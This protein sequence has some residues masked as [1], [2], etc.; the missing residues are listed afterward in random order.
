MFFGLPGVC[1]VRCLVLLMGHASHAINNAIE[2]HTM[3]LSIHTM[4]IL[5]KDRDNFCLAFCQ[6][7]NTKI[8]KP[9]DHL[10]FEDPDTKQRELVL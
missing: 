1:S 10:D 3:P 9:K 8:K 7:W 4:A 2:C 6:R 5:P